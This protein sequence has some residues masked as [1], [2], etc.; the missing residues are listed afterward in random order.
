MARETLSSADLGIFSWKKRSAA[1]GMTRAI[2]A[3]NSIEQHALFTIVLKFCC[4]YFVPPHKK[5]NPGPKNPKPS[6][7]PV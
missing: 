1:V 6:L 3:M 2:H 7:F 4:L 5:Q